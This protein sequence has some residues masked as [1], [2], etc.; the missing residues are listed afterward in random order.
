MSVTK[1]KL[2]KQAYA[3]ADV[4]FN[5]KKITSLAD[6]SSA[7]D[8]ATKNYVDS[9]L[10]AVN[11]LQYKGVI[12][13][14]G[15]P[16]YPAASSGWTYKVSVG[17]KIGGA[18]GVSVVAGDLAICTNDSTA[19]GDQ[20]T[21]GTYW[22]II[23]VAGA[24]GSVSTNDTVAVDNSIV[25]EDGT[26]GATYQKS[27]ASIDDSG[28]IN[29]PSGQSY[30]INNAALNQDNIGDGTTY[31]QYSD[32]EKTKLSGIE[33]SAVSAATVMAKLVTRETPSG[34]KNGSNATFTLANTPVSGTEML[35]LNGILLNAGA[36]NDYTISGGTITMLTGMIPVST[37]VLLCTYWK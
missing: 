7:Q 9:L 33:A 1:I 22:D 18:S 17:G 23:H 11:G 4:D 37:D 35:F 32:T 5:S 19:S 8:A 29:I 21:V 10:D 31:K 27:L 16:N 15:N 14:S 25:R 28:S 20:A 30:K 13:C 3:D 34:T 12:D 6:P 36:G 2:S 26:S 24:S